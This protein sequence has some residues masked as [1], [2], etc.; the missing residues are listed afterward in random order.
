VGIF[1]FPQL[2]DGGFVTAPNL[3]FW[4]PKGEWEVENRGVE[5]LLA[6]LRKNPPPVH[7][8]PEFPNYHNHSNP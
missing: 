3:A 4:T 8:R 1:G 7:K 5:L 6:A 2:M